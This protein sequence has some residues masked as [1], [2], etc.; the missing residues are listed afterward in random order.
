MGGQISPEILWL[1]YSQLFD[2]LRLW[3]LLLLLFH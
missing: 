3:N 1:S 2:N